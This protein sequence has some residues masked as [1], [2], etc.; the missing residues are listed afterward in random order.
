MCKVEKRNY[1]KDA[2]SFP[3]FVEKWQRGMSN[4]MACSCNREFSNAIED[5]CSMGL[6]WE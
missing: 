2:V 1:T 6:A 5:V 3:F 4:R